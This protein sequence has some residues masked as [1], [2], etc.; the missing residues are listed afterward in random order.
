MQKM[1]KFSPFLFYEL[2]TIMNVAKSILALA[3]FNKIKSDT[4][5]EQLTDSSLKEE[6]KR[7]KKSQS[8]KKDNTK[9]NTRGK[10]WKLVDG[11]RVYY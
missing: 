5:L 4:E 3:L 6:Q 1:H 9:E 8:P 7:R 10:H 2:I 11:K